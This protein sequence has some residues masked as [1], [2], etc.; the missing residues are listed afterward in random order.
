[1]SFIQQLA[2]R[3]LVERFKL[4]V[5]RPRP[6]RNLLLKLLDMS[7]NLGK[8]PRPVDDIQERTEVVTIIIGVVRR[9]MRRGRKDDGLVAVHRVE[10]EEPLDALANLAGTVARPLLPISEETKVR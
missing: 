6:I 2:S 7:I 10:A 1:M 3:L 5:R 4:D 9:E 8:L